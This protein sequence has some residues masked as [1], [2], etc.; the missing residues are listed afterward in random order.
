[1]RDSGRSSHQGVSQLVA[2]A[3]AGSTAPFVLAPAVSQSGVERLSSSRRSSSPSPMLAPALAAALASALA[4]FISFF[5][6]RFGSAG[7][8]AELRTPPANIAHSMQ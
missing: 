3:G 2:G 4:A 6:S 1:M 5:S 7:R 8:V